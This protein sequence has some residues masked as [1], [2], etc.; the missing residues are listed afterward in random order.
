MH[1]AHL[2]LCYE[3]QWIGRVCPGLETLC[4]NEMVMYLFM[5][6][7]FLYGAVLALKNKRNTWR[8][9]GRAPTAEIMERKWWD[10]FLL[11]K[12]WRLTVNLWRAHLPF[13]PVPPR[14]LGLWVISKVE[15]GRRGAGSQG[16]RGSL[17]PS[18]TQE[19]GLET[20]L[21]RNDR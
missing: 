7:F 8:R 6:I 18:T 17:S 13:G 15:R 14:W 4:L 5:F 20:H 21:Y 11:C 10:S 2:E 3:I 16:C 19:T 12:K 1:F 9:C